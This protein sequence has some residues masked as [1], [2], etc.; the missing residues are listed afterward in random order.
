MASHTGARPC[1]NVRYTIIDTGTPSSMARYPSATNRRPYL[2]IMARAPVLDGRDGQEDHEGHAEQH[3]R[4]R[5]RAGRVVALDEAVD[6][7]RGD[8]GVERHVAGDEHDRP[9]LADCTSE[10]ERDAGEQRREDRRQDD[11][12]EDGR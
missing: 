2:A 3:H 9:E 1:W 4:E 11:A 8:L 7:D 5:G 6:V 10:P 12:P